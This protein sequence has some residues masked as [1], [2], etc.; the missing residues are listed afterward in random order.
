VCGASEAHPIRYQNSVRPNLSFP[1][2]VCGNPLLISSRFRLKDCRNDK[3][4]S[5]SGQTLNRCKKVAENIRKLALKFL[6]KFK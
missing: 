5:I 1:H 3:N 2:A 6:P 4:R